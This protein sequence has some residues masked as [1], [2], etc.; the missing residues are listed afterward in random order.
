MQRWLPFCT[1]SAQLLL[2]ASCCTTIPVSV[3]DEPLT[4]V[5]G[6]L[7]DPSTYPEFAVLMHFLSTGQADETEAEFAPT[8][9]NSVC[10]PLASFE[11]FN[12]EIG[13]LCSQ[14]TCDY[15]ALAQWRDF[16]G[17]LVKAR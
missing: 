5:K 3:K 9:Q 8:L 2:T 17:R 16:Y 10:M 6:S 14:V 1:I 4:Y 12:T 13:K 11:D 15:A 7:G